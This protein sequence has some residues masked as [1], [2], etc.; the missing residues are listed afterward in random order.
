[1]L[2]LKRWMKRKQPS[3]RTNL[4]AF[5]SCGD[6]KG[7]QWM[8][9]CSHIYIH[10]WC[11]PPDGPGTH[12]PIQVRLILLTPK[13]VRDVITQNLPLDTRIPNS[14]STDHI[15]T[16]IIP[17]LVFQ[18]RIPIMFLSC[19][20]SQFVPGIPGWVLSI[21]CVRNTTTINHQIAKTSVEEK[22]ML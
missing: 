16:Q 2:G 19:S 6:R 12:K 7:K 8:M 17:L 1:M 21:F 22:K 9:Q 11:I 18:I 13:H 5:G 10:Q 14:Y 4:I 15:I 3:C 20:F